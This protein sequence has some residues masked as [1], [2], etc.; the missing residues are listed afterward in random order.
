MRTLLLAALLALPAAAVARPEL[1]LRLGYAS[2]SGEASTGT[3]MSEVAK[4]AV[5][6]QLDA[7]WRFGERFAAGLYSSYGFGQ[8]SSSVS[9]QCGAAGASCSVS[10]TRL[11]AEGI[12]TFTDVSPRYLP[13]LGAGIGYEWVR[14]GASIGSRS[15]VQHLSGWEYLNVQGGA[16]VRV[17]R[18]VAVGLYAQYAFGQY[19]RLDGSTIQSKGFHQWL[20]AGLRGTYDL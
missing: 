15:G 5:P 6:I 11:G 7:L 16:D 4:S 14:E 18:K 3:S 10:A 1:G 20:G 9:D 17:A 8:L 12:W 2:A 19:S 13:W